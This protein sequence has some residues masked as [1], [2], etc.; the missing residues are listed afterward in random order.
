MHSFIEL[1]KLF[2]DKFKSRHF[3]DEPDTLYQPAAYILGIGGKRIRPVCVL[4]GNQLFND[5][6]PDAYH[7]ATAIELFHNFSLI[8]DDIMDKAPLRRGMQTVHEKYGESTALLAGDV[9]FVK[10]YEY[11]NK[12]RPAMLQKVL[13]LFNNTASA[14]C[15]GQQLDMDFEKRE[16]VR[17][18]EY[19]NMI[20]LKTSVLMAASLKLGAI[21]GGA[22]EGNQNHL[23]EFGK[24]LGVAFQVQDDYL[25]AFGNPEK[26]GK[27]V[28]GDIM[29]NK[30]T[31]L[32]IHAFETANVQQLNELKLLIKNNPADKVEKIL[33]IFKDCKVDD[34]A[35]QLKNKYLQ[36]ALM[37]LEETAVISK[38]KKPLQE[39]ADYLMMRES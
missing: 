39:L 36:T 18:D 14:V 9:M 25:D 17:M 13:Y 38:R 20:T 2:E 12:I 8:H 28:G 6:D 23:Y 35:Q 31:F 26:F 22:G 33:Q 21:L 29:A 27:K 19:V 16:I 7:A 4:M 10:A 32:M 5:I 30:K 11:L 24:N 34:W 37:H 15:E 1:S 3:P